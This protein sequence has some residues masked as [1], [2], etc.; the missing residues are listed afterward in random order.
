MRFQT[1]NVNGVFRVMDTVDGKYITK[2]IPTEGI[3]DEI[4]DQFNA[5]ENKDFTPIGGPDFSKSKARN[6]NVN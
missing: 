6:V 5:M 4:A 2:D 3:A 1:K